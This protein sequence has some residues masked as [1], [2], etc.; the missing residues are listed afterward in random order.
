[1]T[2]SQS[3]IAAFTEMAARYEQTVDRELRQFWGIGYADFISQLIDRLDVP[4]AGL[5]LDVATGRGVIPLALTERA[6]WTGRVVG[7]DITPEMLKG[8]R[9][10]LAE[11]G[12]SGRVALVCGSGMRLP[13]GDATFDTAICALATHH[14]DVPALL[15]Q[16]HRVL[17]PG[18]QLLIAD[19]A[20]A[21]L[22]RTLPGRALLRILAW[23][24]GRREGAARMQAEME[25]V[26]NMLTP[27][28]WR[29]ALT[30]AGFTIVDLTTLPAR[31]AWYPPGILAKAAST[32]LPGAAHP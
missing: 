26:P 19:V 2:N 31:R 32:N 24:Y 20:L 25:A 1:M 27:E 17:R 23:W 10:G 28:Q 9:Q 29:N 3:I 22:F 14:M 5:T 13:F 16:L 15:R 30:G 12:A 4:A 18:G 11:R 21:H 8:A 6:G 7:L